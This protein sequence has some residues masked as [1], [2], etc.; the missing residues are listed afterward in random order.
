[1]LKFT[2]SLTGEKTDFTP[3]DPGKVSVYWCG[4]TVY[5]A[6]HL[7]HARATMAI[8]ILVRYLRWSGYEVKAVSNITDI[9]DK[10]ITRAAEEGTS[11]PDLAE[12]FEE[13]FIAEM[14]RLNIACL[15]YTSDAADE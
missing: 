15:L 1:M 7:G 4:P 11:E 12:R 5:D 13:I 2:D 8:D 3:R 9:D 10:I 14:D 6:P